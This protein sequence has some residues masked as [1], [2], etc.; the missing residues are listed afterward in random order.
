LLW[1]CDFLKN[2]VPTRVGSFRGAPQW[3][4]AHFFSGAL[5]MSISLGLGLVVPLYPLGL[6]G[7][8]FT[9]FVWSPVRVGYI[10][11]EEGVCG[12]SWSIRL[13]LR[14]SISFLRVRFSSVS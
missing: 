9:L 14:L 6:P 13:R 2:V 12:F 1:I 5:V 3:L 7:K 11:L 10:R 8:R 4:Q